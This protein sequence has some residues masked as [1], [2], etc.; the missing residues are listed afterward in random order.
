MKDTKKALLTISYIN[1]QKSTDFKPQEKRERKTGHACSGG[2]GGW[3][4]PIGRKKERKLGKGRDR[5]EKIETK[6][7]KGLDTCKARVAPTCI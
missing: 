4:G 7:K 3:R 1:V 5:E 2:G 6:R